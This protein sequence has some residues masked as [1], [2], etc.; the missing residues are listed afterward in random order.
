MLHPFTVSVLN[1]FRLNHNFK[2]QCQ[3]QSPLT[4]CRLLK[5]LPLLTIQRSFNI[6]SFS[7]QK[8]QSSFNG[9]FRLF[10]L[11]SSDNGKVALF[12]SFLFH[13]VYSQ[14]TISS[15][16]HN[17]LP[18]LAC[19]LGDIEIS[20]EEVYMYNALSS[21]NFAKVTGLNANSRPG[22]GRMFLWSV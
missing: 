12:N 22:F 21:L 13:S 3:S 5:K 18:P 17:F 9:I 16:N 2:K 19:C 14:G 20:L 4:S 8:C 6:F 15:P 7:F 11:A 1:C 10:L